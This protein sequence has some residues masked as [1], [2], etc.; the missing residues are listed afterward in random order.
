MSVSANNCKIAQ[1]TSLWT[2]NSQQRGRFVWW[3]PSL[4]LGVRSCLSEHAT[5]VST[6]LKDCLCLFV[7]P[8]RWASTHRVLHLC[9][10]STSPS[11]YKACCLLY[12]GRR[13][14]ARQR[15]VLLHPKPL[16]NLGKHVFPSLQAQRWVF[17]AW[18]EEA[19]VN[20]P[21]RKGTLARHAGIQL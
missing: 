11:M 14:S 20:N 21:K 18:V 9:L 4:W 12:N 19:T 6:S 17:G 10:H 5:T 7:T 16:N 2:L 1:N 8:F 13:V 15:F 3:S